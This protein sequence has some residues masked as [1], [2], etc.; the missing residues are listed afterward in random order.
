VAN[1]DQRPTVSADNFYAFKDSIEM[2]GFMKRNPMNIAVEQNDH[3]FLKL[4]VKSVTK[5]LLTD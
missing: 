1:E 4:T 2:Y 3:S 5:L